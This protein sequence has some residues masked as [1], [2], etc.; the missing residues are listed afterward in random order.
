MKILIFGG[1]LRNKYLFEEL[2]KENIGADLQAY[3]YKSIDDLSK[4]KNFSVT[5][6]QNKKYFSLINVKNS[7]T[8]ESEGKIN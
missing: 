8:E 1:D 2:L 5:Q 7:L 3:I 4:I 6:N